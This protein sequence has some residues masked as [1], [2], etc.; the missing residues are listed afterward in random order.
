M[1]RFTVP[2]KSGARQH[3]AAVPRNRQQ[4]RQPSSLPITSNHDGRGARRGVAKAAGKG[5][6]SRDAGRARA[7]TTVGERIA[8]GRTPQPLAPTAPSASHAEAQTNPNRSRR[9]P[10]LLLA[11]RNAAIVHGKA[12]GA[13]GLGA[14]TRGASGLD[15]PNFVHAHPRN[16]LCGDAEREPNAACPRRASSRRRHRRNA[17]RRSGGGL[18]RVH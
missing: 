13:S 18:L 11:A 2:N 15:P 8:R 16:E 3:L 9:A 6:A 4:Q 17:A 12:P 5:L 7:A 14:R 1:E 10:L